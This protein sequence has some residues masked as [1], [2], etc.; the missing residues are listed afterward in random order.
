MAIYDPVDMKSY[1]SASV[2]ATASPSFGIPRDVIRIFRQIS[3]AP[4]TGGVAIL[5]IRDMIPAMTNQDG[6]AGT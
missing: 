1:T 5:T 6:S 4:E 2:L 3:V